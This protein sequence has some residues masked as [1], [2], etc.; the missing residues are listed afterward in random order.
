[1]THPDIA[2]IYRETVGR[3]GFKGINRQ[4]AFEE[5]TALV[6]T[7]IRAGRLELD[8]DSAVRAALKDADHADGRS[9]DRILKSAAL[10]DVPLDGYD[11][12]V[13]VTLGGGLRKQWADVDANDLRDMDVL[14]YQN[15]RNAQNA[16]DEWRTSYDAVLPVLFEFR[17]FGAAFTGGG[18]PPSST[19]ASPE[20]AA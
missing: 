7:E 3:S 13:V 2:R 14:R 6:M 11:I 5:A 1:M 4:D 16:Y 17:T 20:V 19:V 9:A 8:V 18:F 10:G 12:N 15:V